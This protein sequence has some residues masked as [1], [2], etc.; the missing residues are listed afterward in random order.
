MKTTLF[1]TLIL[2]ITSLTNLNAQ[3]PCPLSNKMKEGSCITIEYP[4]AEAASKAVRAPAETLVISESVQEASNGVYIAQFACSGTEVVYTKA[5]T[6][7]CNGYEGVVLGKFKFTIGD[8][9]CLYDA[10]GVLPVDFSYFM[11][12]ADKDIAVLKWGTSSET[13]NDGF[14]VEKS[15]DGH[16]FQEFAFIVGEGTSSAGRG[17]GSG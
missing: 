10:A 7:T 2:L 17:R 1:F 4:S 9:T 3:D 11:A 5:G 12:E 15:T 14:Y 8:M 6:C 13:N 16:F